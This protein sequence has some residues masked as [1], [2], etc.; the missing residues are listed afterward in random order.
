MLFFYIMQTR[1]S[2]KLY[3]DSNQLLEVKDKLSNWVQINL[4][5]AFKTDKF[6]EY[7]KEILQDFL[8]NITDVCSE[9]NYDMDK[10]RKIFETELQVLNTQLKS[11]ADKVTDIE[12]FEIKWFIQIIAAWTLI[13]S[14]IWDVSLLIFRNK[15]LYF[16]VLNEES[17]NGKIDLFSDFIEWEVEKEDELVYIWDNIKNIVDKTDIS[18][19]EEVLATDEH[20]LISIFHELISSRVDVEKV[21]F[22]NSFYIHGNI[23]HQETSVWKKYNF[24][25]AKN[26][27]PNIKVNK[28]YVTV[29]LLVVLILFLLY[30]VLSSIF[31]TSEQSLFEQED[32]TFVDLTIEDIKQSIFDFQSMDP[33]SDDKSRMYTEIMS[34]I[35]FLESQW[36]WIEDVQN[37]KSILESDYYK[38]FNIMVVNNMTEFDSLATGIKASVLAFNTVEKEKI[39]NPISIDYSRWIYV[40]WETASILWASNEANRWSV[41]EYLVDSNMQ[42]CS[43]SINGD[44]LYCYSE[45][46]RIFLATKQSVTP[47]EVAN[48]AGFSDTIWWIS[49]FWRNLYV[50]QKTLNSEYKWALTTRYAMN[51]SSQSSF[52]AGQ[53]YTVPEE[54]NIPTETEFV[55]HEID[56]SFLAWNNGALYQFWRP[57]GGGVVLS[58]REIPL[59]WGAMIGDAYSNNVEVLANANSDYVMLLDKDN[60]TLTVYK[61]VSNKTN[62]NYKYTYSLSYLMS[63]KFDIDWETLI[64][65]D[66]DSTTWDR[67]ETYLLTN[68]WVYRLSVDEFIEKLEV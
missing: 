4:L 5:V 49:I 11:F 29:G 68:N 60:Q 35:E 2:Q 30:N 1:Q 16:E 18:D 53:N 56:G 33:S 55:W 12:R 37:L 40:W 10:I 62:E 47:L 67:M 63:F 39:W 59:I 46:S 50:F 51:G 21:C 26:L 64:D 42:D 57:D 6:L 44:W 36:M 54:S 24:S 28:F 14:M 20:D 25:M 34:Q 32:G 65:A 31:Q 7:Q 19:L 27:V 61:S 58:N 15:K 45:D 43:I 8:A 3:L 48:E 23:V 52:R 22:A 41:T 13:S 9:E 38:G 17:S 66:V